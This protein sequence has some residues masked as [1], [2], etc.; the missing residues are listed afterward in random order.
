MRGYL[1]LSVVAL[2][3]ETAL[4]QNLSDPTGICRNN[5]N[6]NALNSFY[7]NLSTLDTPTNTSSY[8]ANEFRVYG[9]CCNLNNFNSVINRTRNTS[10][11][12]NTFMKTQYTQ[13][14]NAVT[15]MRNFIVE[16][17]N[18]PVSIGNSR[19][20]TQ[21]AAAQALI[22]D[23]FMGPYL[24]NHNT[25][26]AIEF[27]TSMDQCWP[28]AQRIRESALCIQ[29]S[30][31][32]QYFLGD[33][34]GLG[35]L[36]L[37]NTSCNY[38]QCKFAH[39]RIVAFVQDVDFMFNFLPGLFSTFGI[40]N[41]FA[42]VVNRARIA[43]YAERF[44]D[45]SFFNLSRRAES[46]EAAART[47]ICTMFLSAGG[48]LLH[49]TASTFF[50]RNQN[51][52]VTSILS[53]ISNLEPS[54]VASAAEVS[55][56]ARDINR[57]MDGFEIESVANSSNPNTTYAVSNI[58]VPLPPV[59]P[60]LPITRRRLQGVNNLFN[61]NLGR[62]IV[63]VTEY[64]DELAR[65]NTILSGGAGRANQIRN[66]FVNPPNP[67][68]S[69]RGS[70]LGAN[71]LI[72]NGGP[73]TFTNQET[74]LA[75]VA[76]RPFGAVRPYDN[77]APNSQPDYL[78]LRLSPF[79][80]FYT[81]VNLVAITGNTTNNTNTTNGTNGTNTTN[82]TNGTNTTN[83]TNG[84]NTT[85][86]TNGTNTTNGTNGTNTTNGTNGT[87]TTNGTNGTNTTNGTNGTNTTNGTNGTN[88]TNGTNGTNTT[89][90]TNGTNTTNITP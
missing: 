80:R 87:N 90:G 67:F 24:N 63:N 29:C 60:L 8:C 46:G 27:N 10:L 68:F 55:N 28:N 3:F 79:L 36:T 85:N 57:T 37:N 44:R 38:D 78:T 7:A 47:Q 84:T 64:D 75:L 15:Q 26:L 50:T 11:E 89:N 43:Q 86:G 56:I 83:G 39:E 49:E 23:P 66:T 1:A 69:V 48:P 40:S 74:T 45:G 51:F 34:S 88:T 5:T 42:L 54:V 4:Q 13:F 77:P 62:D 19:A 53:T 81:P 35:R 32:S 6:R 59:P 22:A 41:N 71:N 21:Q 65:V 20:A 76:N 17:A 31:R 16:I 30:G 33:A 61:G 12:A 18:K 73:L 82:G 72:L 14:I 9:S 52:T 58:T 25:S 2:F 70:V